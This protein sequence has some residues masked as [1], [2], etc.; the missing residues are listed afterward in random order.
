MADGEHFLHVDVETKTLISSLGLVMFVGREVTKRQ[1]THFL[2][3]H[4]RTHTGILCANAGMPK[5]P[6]LTSLFHR[7]ARTGC[8]SDMANNHRG[9]EVNENAKVKT[10]V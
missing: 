5:V 4:T 10:Q 6:R 3:T 9:E 1:E 2:T 8:H 7:V